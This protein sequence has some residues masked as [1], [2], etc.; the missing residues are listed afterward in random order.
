MMQTAGWCV[1]LGGTTALDTFG[2]QAFT[3]SPK[4]TDV[5]VHL[6]R[7]LFWL[8][9]ILGPV[10]VLWWFCEPVLLALKQEQEIAHDVQRFLR[11]LVVGAPGYICFESMRKYL[12]CQGASE[13]LSARCRIPMLRPGIMEAGTYVLLV[14]SPLNVAL[15]VWLVLHTGWALLGAPLAISIT[16]WTSFL[17]LVTY[18]SV[19]TAH[20][21]NGTWGGLQLQKA[22]SL[23]G[24]IE[25]L[26]IAVPGILMVGTEWWA[27]E[28]VAIAAGQL[29]A[30]PLSAQACIMTVDQVLN[31]I[32]FGL[33]QSARL[34][35]RVAVAMTDRRRRRVRSG[36]KHAG[37]EVGERSAHCGARGCGAQRRARQRRDDCDAGDASGKRP[38]PST[39][40]PAATSDRI[41]ATCSPTTMRQSH[42]LQRFCL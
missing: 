18:A 24:G 16:Y 17:L 15:N 6:Q 4:K 21:Q 9:L 8:H 32:P 23:R 31:T 14:T 41:S 3:G 35:A 30:L 25:F 38:P 5:G 37:M 26:K 19:S 22:T 33:G 11:V 2:S 28:I 13:I 34:G 7:C 10:L 39:W 1:A 36:R 29:G 12:Q 27:F 42:W 40:M 20:A